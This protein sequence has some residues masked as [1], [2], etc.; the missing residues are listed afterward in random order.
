MKTLIIYYSN[1][2]TTEIVAKTIARQL[3]C[4]LCQVKD[5]KKRKGFTGRFTS[6]IDAFRETKTEI[7]PPKLDLTEF[8]TIYFGTPTWANNPAPAITTMI[9]RCNLIGKDVILFTTV[10]NSGGE[11]TIEKMETKVN[12]RGGRVIERFSIKTKDKDKEEII[13]SSESIVQSLDLKMYNL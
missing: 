11:T 3:G 4:Y 6:T 9:D 8:D 10:A 1:E 7:Y 12:S 13:I 2:G 5:L